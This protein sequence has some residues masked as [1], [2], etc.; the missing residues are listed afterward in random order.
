MR[1]SQAVYRLPLLNVLLWGIKRKLHLLAG[2]TS[3]PVA[4][5]I[6]TGTTGSEVASTTV[7][8]AIQIGPSPFPKRH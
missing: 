8:R 1:V 6:S 2:P 4:E 3:H 5:P 7:R